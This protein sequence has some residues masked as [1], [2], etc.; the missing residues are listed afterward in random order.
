MFRRSVVTA[1]AALL[2]VGGLV[3]C[4]DAG[5]DVEEG[6][7][8]TVEAPGDDVNGDDGDAPSP[9]EEWEVTLTVEEGCWEIWYRQGDAEYRSRE[10]PSDWTPG[11]THQG[12]MVAES[13]T[14]LRFETD[15][16]EVAEF[17]GGVGAGFTMDCP[18]FDGDLPPEDVAPLPDN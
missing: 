3:S 10:F 11:S 17:H 15:D 7:T 14:E 18:V 4:A 12:T 13:E 1:A 6:S 9:G 8:T 16:G 2:L 5:E